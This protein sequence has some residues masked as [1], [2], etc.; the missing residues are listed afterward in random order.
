MKTNIED[1]YFTTQEPISEEEKEELEARYDLTLEKQQYVDLEYHDTKL[2]LH[3]QT[4]NVDL[5][6]ISEGRDIESGDELVLTYNYAKANSIA[7]GDKLKLAGREFTV[8]GLGMKSDYAIM[9]YD[10]SETI[11]NKSGFGIGIITQETMA[12]LGTPMEFYSVRYRDPEQEYAFREKL[13]QKKSRIFNG[14]NAKLPVI[15]SI[16]SL[17]INGFRSLTFVIGIAIA[18]LCIVLGGSFEDAY[19]HLLKV[20]VPDAML[21]G[22]Y[23]YGFQSFQTENPYGGAAV[24]DIS[25]G[26][27]KDN[28]RFN[29]I[30]YEP[31]NGI[32]NTQTVEGAEL[33]Y[34]KYYMTSAAANKYGVAKGDSFCFYNTVTMQET[35]VTI[36]GIVKNDILPLVL[37]SKENVAQLLNRPLEE[38]NVIISK[39]KLTIPNG[40]LKK[41]ASIQD[42][43]VQV[44]SLST[45]AGIVLK[46]LKVLGM[47][48]CLLIVTMMSGFIIG[49][50]SRNISMLEVLGYRKGEVRR[51]VLTVN[52]FLVPVGFILGVP[53][54]YLVAYSM[55]LSAA[56]S[57]GRLMSL[58]VRPAT[59]LGSFVFVLAAYGIAM[60]LAGRKLK[61]VDM[62]E[63][64]KC[65]NE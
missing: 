58:P 40:L 27:K 63:S 2:R 15:Y 20:K 10:L 19:D 55:I 21:G 4:Q 64:L 5:Y 50:S 22:Q 59:L 62:V 29:M 42:Y 36:S 28:S 9:L 13:Y 26:A 23:E 32:L 57:S 30:G 48:I 60:A 11:P 31:D 1:G 65:P 61:K 14:S 51:F 56:Q 52:H 6:T 39:E 53:L 44:R 8:C 49:E 12:E 34:G 41:N 33:E 18:T 38:Y 46:L 47:L 16:R 54:G 3:T 17:T 7:V 45:T 35:T 24:F 25:F 43:E 37:T